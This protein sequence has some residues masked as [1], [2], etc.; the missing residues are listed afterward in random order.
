MV[1]ISRRHRATVFE[2][3]LKEVRR[4]RVGEKDIARVG[5]E[6][7]VDFTARPGAPCPPTSKLSLQKQVRQEVMK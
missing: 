6:S 7:R 2:S 5:A 4:L 3:S 1:H